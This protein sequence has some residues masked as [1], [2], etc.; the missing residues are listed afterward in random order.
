[1]PIVLVGNKSDLQDQREV[2]RK[3]GEELAKKMGCIPFMEASAKTG[4]NVNEMFVELVKLLPPPIEKSN[5]DKGNC[6]L[7]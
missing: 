3:Q 5:H 1:V 2:S 6:V 4:V 7:L